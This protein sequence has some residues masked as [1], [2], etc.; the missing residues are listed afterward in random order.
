[1]I[2][3]LVNKFVTRLTCKHHWY[4]LKTVEVY[5]EFGHDA[6]VYICTCDKCGKLKKKRV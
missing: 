2:K 5:S 3:K 4:I 1:M 6:T